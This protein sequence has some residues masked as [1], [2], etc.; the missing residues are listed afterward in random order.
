MIERNIHQIWIQGVSDVPT[1]FHTN[2]NKIKKHN[3][4]WKYK[5]WD[6]LSIIKLLTINQ[7]WLDKYNSFEYIHQKADFARYIIL[8]LHGG[9]YIDIDAYTIK[10]L[11]QLFV[12]YKDKEL[13]VSSLK[14]NMVENIFMCSN[15][16]CYNNGIIICKKGNIIMKQII[17][18]ILKSD[19]CVNDSKNGMYPK[20]NWSNYVL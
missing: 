3:R 13:I 6:E 4:S 5:I 14:T 18:N 17:N 20:N 12:D 9:I 1:K 8:Y 11:E 10:P 2:M 7:M 15:T 16:K 19:K